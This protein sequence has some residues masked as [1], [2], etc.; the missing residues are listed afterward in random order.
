[1]SLFFLFAAS[2]FAAMNNHQLLQVLVLPHVGGHRA[3]QGVEGDA[4]NLVEQR[5]LTRDAEGDLERVH[6]LHDGAQ[7]D[8]AVEPAIRYAQDKRL[9][10]AWWW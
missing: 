5:H 4:L 7:L 8:A 6:L 2:L 9:Q 1:M 10:L 3:R